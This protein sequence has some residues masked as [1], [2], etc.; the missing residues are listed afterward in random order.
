MLH[1]LRTDL[2]TPP[3][4]WQ[5]H[6]RGTKKLGLKAQHTMRSNNRSSSDWA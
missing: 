5:V 6:L 1:C 3:R 2:P 4:D